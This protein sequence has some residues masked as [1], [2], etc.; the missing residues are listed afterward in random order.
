MGITHNVYA[1]PRRPLHFEFQCAVSLAA[2]PVNE[3][4][5]VLA[6]LLLKVGCYVDMGW[7][8]NDLAV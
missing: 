6:S 2:C 3:E 1:C 8:Q 4:P 7:W 5:V